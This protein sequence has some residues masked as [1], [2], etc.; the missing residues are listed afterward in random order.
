MHCSDV[1]V[2]VASMFLLDN[3]SKEL[4][5]DSHQFQ[6]LPNCESLLVLSS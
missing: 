4:D 1:P 5:L 6:A 3:I 2:P